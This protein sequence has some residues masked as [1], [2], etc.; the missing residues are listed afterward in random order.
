MNHEF[1]PPERRVSVV[2]RSSEASA[3]IAVCEHSRPPV[4]ITSL[5]LALL[6]PVLQPA[7]RVFVAALVGYVLNESMPDE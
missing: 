3:E 6:V 4:G 1:R 5:S 7:G 2:S